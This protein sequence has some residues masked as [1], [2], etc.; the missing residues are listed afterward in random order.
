M[1]TVLE[2]ITSAGTPPSERVSSEDSRLAESARTLLGY[3]GYAEF[4]RKQTDEAPLRYQ[5]LHFLEEEFG[6]LP[7]KQSTVDA[8]KAAK[9]KKH[10]TIVARMATFTK[11]GIS[12]AI[13]GS[14][15]VGVIVWGIT[16]AMYWLTSSVL[17][18]LTSFA[19][20]CIGTVFML[21]FI[22]YMAVS[23]APRSRWHRIET[24]DYGPPVPTVALRR[25][26][27]LKEAFGDSVSFSIE[28]LTSRGRD[29]LLNQRAQ[30]EEAY[31]RWL[32]EDP[33]LILHINHKNGVTEDLTIAVWDEPAFDT[34]LA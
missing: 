30:R 31:Q 14:L 17:L 25:M 3:G 9:V 33:F 6:W 29:S 7:F 12:A 34:E 2:R 23:D 24:K 1:E 32:R 20:G 4:Q 26:I 15:V 10:S 28:H 27:Q 13:F 22:T 21:G 11:E 5:V 16:A 8:Y 18:G 19:V